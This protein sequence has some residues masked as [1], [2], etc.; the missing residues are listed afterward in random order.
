MKTKFLFILIVLLTSTLALAQDEGANEL[1]S[2]LPQGC[3]KE[4]ITFLQ[5]GQLILG[6]QNNPSNQQIYLIRNRSD[7]TQIVLAHP[8]TTE[9][10]AGWTSRLDE[11][12]WSAITVTGLPFNLTCFG[13]KP[14][15]IG[16]VDCQSVLMVCSYP[17]VTT[18]GTGGNYWVSENKGLI[19]TLSTLKMRGVTT[20]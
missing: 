10:N 18:E 14:G 15:A 20:P 16:Y 7:Y 19:D 9:M 17:N 12:Q 8:T 1:V 13:R 3:G 6:N 2:S 5:N 4:G 11:G